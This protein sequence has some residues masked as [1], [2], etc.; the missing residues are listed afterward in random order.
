MTDFSKLIDA[1]RIERAHGDYAALQTA[2]RDAQ[3]ALTQAQADAKSAHSRA[4]AAADRGD[5]PAKLEAAEVAVDSA[6]RAVRMT[7]RL[8]E[9]SRKHRTAGEA[10]LVN[11]VRQAHGAAMNAAMQRLIEIR[12]EAIDA[13]RRV[14]E[15]KA[16]HIAVRDSFIRMAHEAKAGLPNYVESSSALIGT[17]GKMMD[18][19]EFANRL[20]QAHSNEW[21]ADTNK[22][23]WV[24]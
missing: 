6:E 18:E 20:S 16:E 13:F 11:E 2:E 15:L 8:L 12:G 23:R 17:N 21:N 5:A 24:G 1:K 10:T 9:A 19:S 7:G 4:Q 3:T 22:L 14:E